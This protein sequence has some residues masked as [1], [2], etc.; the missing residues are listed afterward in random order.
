MGEMG[1]SFDV[2][3]E[4][5]DYG[6]G[7]AARVLF[8]ALEREHSGGGWV[9]SSECV[10][11]SGL[12]RSDCE[13]AATY[14]AARLD[15][16]VEIRDGELAYRFPDTDEA[17]AELSSGGRVGHW[18]LEWA[19]RW[20]QWMYRA[21]VGVAALLIAA[22]VGT[23][24]LWSGSAIYSVGTGSGT[25]LGVL[26]GLVFGVPLVLVGVFF[27]VPVVAVF[28]IVV[29]LGLVVA[30]GALGESLLGIVGLSMAVASGFVLVA[31]MYGKY[32]FLIERAREFAGLFGVD[33]LFRR[34]LGEELADERTF[35]R[36]AASWDGVVTARDLVAMFGWS[37]ERARDELTR[38]LL[39][40]GG[41]IE[42]TG[43]G[44]IV[45]RFPDLAG[46]GGGEAPAPVWEREES[47]MERFR[48]RSGGAQ[49]K[50]LGVWGAA[51]VGLGAPTL[52]SVA[53][54]EVFGETE[55]TAAGSVWPYLVAAGYWLTVGAVVAVP[56]GILLRHLVLWVQESRYAER[57]EFLEMVRLAV[58]ASDGVRV[59]PDEIDEQAV[60][61]LGGEVDYEATGADGKVRLHFP[62][63]E[64]ERQS[65]KAK[66]ES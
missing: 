48:R 60:A 19:T 14:L 33:A 31:L 44:A 23:A 41:D 59:D 26:A 32:A 20:R 65:G 39:D 12:P 40:Y 28:G 47:P 55:A 50:L 61:K 9:T 11:I 64:L 3:I 49:W 36:R 46:G 18:R 42:V 21:L 15:A 10:A 52:L 1:E 29:G 6:E 30:W 54:F 56:V 34:D 58:E 62:E 2:H 38:L 57:E 53:G 5:K 43:E 24:G 35:T 4:A 45:Y 13:D 51:V 22:L 27:M 7:N 16:P 66:A 63:M 8:E 25:E 37:R 17:P